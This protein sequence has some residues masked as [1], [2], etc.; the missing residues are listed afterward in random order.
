MTTRTT[1]FRSGLLAT[2]LAL[3]AGF[4]GPAGPGGFAAGRAFTCRGGERPADGP[5]GRDRPLHR[6]NRYCP[7]PPFFGASGQLAEQIKAG[8][9]RGRVPLGQSQVRSGSGQSGLRSA[10]T[11][12]IRMPSE[13]WSWQSERESAGSIRSLHDLAR[14]EVKKVAL[15]NPA[16]APYGAAGKQAL[17]RSGLWAKVEPKV[18]QSESIRQAFQYV[19]SGN[20]EAGLVGRAIAKRSRNQPGER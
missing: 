7:S 8:R 20:A 5:P 4:A 1:A 9:S 17:E 6:A 11:R 13:L 14:P 15:A 18:V 2:G 19:Q 16:L 10:R 3:V 12:C